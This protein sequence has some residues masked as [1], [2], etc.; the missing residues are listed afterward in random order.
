LATVRG[1]GAAGTSVP[2]IVAV[3]CFD[4]GPATVIRAETVELIVARVVGA[5]I[6]TTHTLTGSWAGTEPVVLAGVRL[7]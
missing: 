5:A 6:E 3:T 7:R 4:Q 1:S 2:E